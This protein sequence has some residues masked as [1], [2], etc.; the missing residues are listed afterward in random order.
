LWISRLAALGAV[1]YVLAVCGCATPPGPARDVTPATVQGFLDKYGLDF[2]LYKQSDFSDPERFFLH[3]RLYVVQ[4][5]LEKL[6]EVYV[7]INP[8]VAW[9]TPRTHFGIVW[10]PASARR[11][12][13]RDA[14]IP[15]FCIGQIYI[16]ELLL[17]G[18]YRIPVAF[19]IS[20]IDKTE[21]V[22][23]FVYLKNNVSSGRQ[24]LR[25]TE[26]QDSE[27]RTFSL[28]EHTTWYRSGKT[29]RD[30]YLYAPFHDKI[31]DA[32]HRQIL[33]SGGFSFKIKNKDKADP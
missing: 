18:F 6:W 5:P 7:S 28:I 12:R 26:S 23:E 2:S 10:D 15:S 16:L 30:K 9:E 25:F 29:F 27:G 21:H 19:E 4:A 14:S 32:Y 3:R 8:L 1:L 22:I 11:Y 20:R 17:T 33:R 31:I 13:A 24:V